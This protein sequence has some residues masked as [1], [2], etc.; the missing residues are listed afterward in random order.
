MK[1]EDGLEKNAELR[2][3]VDNH[4]PA[5]RSQGKVACLSVYK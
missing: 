2:L 4:K 1:I 5:Q 3:E